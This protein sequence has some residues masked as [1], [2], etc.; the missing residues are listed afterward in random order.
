MKYADP[1]IDR[2]DPKRHC[3]YRLFREH[4][5][6]INSV[7]IKDIVRLGRPLKDM[8][9]IDNTP[10]SFAL[11]VENGIPIKSWYDDKRDRELYL[12]T[13]ILEFLAYSNDIRDYIKKF[14]IANEVS[15][16]LAYNIVSSNNKIG[17]SKADFP[18]QIEAKPIIRNTQEGASIPSIN[19]NYNKNVPIKIMQPN[20][21]PYSPSTVV[22]APNEGK[23][24]NILY[25]HN[26]FNNYIINTQNEFK[27]DDKDKKN[28]ILKSPT[29]D[30][31]SFRT[32]Y[33]GDYSSNYR[34]DPQ[35]KY[36]LKVTGNE[37][38]VQ[39]VNDLT[40]RY[41]QYNPNSQ[42]MYNP[43]PNV[44]SNSSM[45]AQQNY[46]NSPNSNNESIIT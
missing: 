19:P 41:G 33:I 29:D 6:Y 27:K 45:F 28:P 32:S 43:N 5:T 14:C 35:S 11:Q 12:L 7:Y 30:K 40:N 16:K 20:L 10:T 1:L 37:G 46:L 17:E 15:Y 36:S 25:I 2:L 3:N 26:D 34:D 42:I 13:P 8:I 18:R 21:N 22:Q 38:K 23:N 39:V 9:I 4:C 31:K 44:I 24:I